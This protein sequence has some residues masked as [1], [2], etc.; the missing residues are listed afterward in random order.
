MKNKF[1]RII[2]TKPKVQE[3]ALSK[4][5]SSKEEEGEQTI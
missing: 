5:V 3:V 4:V 1:E 2:H